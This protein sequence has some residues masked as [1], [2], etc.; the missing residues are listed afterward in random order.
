MMEP[1]SLQTCATDSYRFKCIQTP[2][3]EKFMLNLRSLLCLLSL[4]LVLS[5][6]ARAQD[7]QSAPVRLGSTLVNVPVIVSDRQ[8]RYLSGLKLS[9]FTLFKDHAT[10]SIAV[11]EATEEP[12]NVALLL[13]TSKSTS[14]VLDKIKDAAL[15]F[16]KRLRPRDRA[17]IVSFDYEPHILSALT[18][19]RKALERAVKQAEIGEYVGTTLYDAVMKVTRESLKGVDG[20]KAIIL[21]TDGKDHGSAVSESELLDAAT[22]LDAMVYSIFYNTGLPQ[23]F[24]D[25]DSPRGRRGG[26]GRRGGG[27]RFPRRRPGGERRRERMERNNEDAAEFLTELADASAG[28]FYPSEVTDLKKTFDLIADELRHQY[29]LGFYANDDKPDGS[30]HRLTVQVARPDAVVRARHSYRSAQ[31]SDLQPSSRF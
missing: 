2:S 19:D 1:R 4:A 30:L 18:S 5:L 17:M 23:R 26:W 9:D 29:R 11:F 22:E 3:R 13:D 20:R 24:K 16:L 10:Q 14:D 7:N 8:G 28:R 25:G 12:L 15:D 21:L 27:D 31:T 6:N